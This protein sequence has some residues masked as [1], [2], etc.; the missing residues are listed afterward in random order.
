MILSGFKFILKTPLT[1]ALAFQTDRPNNSDFAQF[2]A[3]QSNTFEI[4]ASAI[5]TTNKSS[6]ENREILDNYGMSTLDLSGTGF[7]DNSIIVKNLEQN[8]ISQKIRWFLLERED[9]RRFI[10]KCKITNISAEGAHDG[11]VSF[12]IALMSS[13]VIYILDESG[14]EY[15]SGTRV[16]T[17]FN[18][19]APQLL[20]RVLSS[21]SYALGDLPSDPAATFKT[22]LTAQADSV[23]TAL[24]ENTLLSSNRLSISVTASSREFAY[25]IL[26]I[27]KTELENRTLQAVDE[28][29]NEI[30]LE[31]LQTVDAVTSNAYFIDAP[32]LSTESLS[33]KINAG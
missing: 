4:A 23:F 17:A 27:N 20:I 10:S 5:E 9:G 3:I 1:D 2:G 24:T 33:L 22:F 32:K 28:L 31:F 11:A 15:D 29:S 16:I 6:A 13:G 12:S 18:N 25:P 26:L 14:Q 19:L 21:P 30:N 7:T 8:V